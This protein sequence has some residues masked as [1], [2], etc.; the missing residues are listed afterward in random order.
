MGSQLLPQ[1][2]SMKEL[3]LITAVMA[4]KIK[5]MKTVNPISTIPLS[6]KRARLVNSWYS[7]SSSIEGINSLQT[8]P[9]SRITSCKH[10]TREVKTKL[11]VLKGRVSLNRG[12]FHWMK[13]WEHNILSLLKKSIICLRNLINL[14]CSFL[15]ISRIRSNSTIL[16]KRR[17]TSGYKRNLAW[18]NLKRDNAWK[19]KLMN[20]QRHMDS[21]LTH[22]EKQAKRMIS[23][24]FWAPAYFLHH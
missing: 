15:I 16:I 17:N 20:S 13:S 12:T 6:I 11:R 21:R 3:P 19:I 7:N 24:H 2:S 9:C 1:P 8:C 22:Q 18:P 10:N 4:D 23:S 5:H 14:K